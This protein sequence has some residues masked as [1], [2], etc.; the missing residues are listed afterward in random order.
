MNNGFPGILHRRNQPLMDDS[1]VSIGFSIT[2]YTSG[3]HGQSQ[4]TFG[5]DRLGSAMDNSHSHGERGLRRSNHAPAQDDGCRLVLGLGPTPDA[6][7]ADQL[8]AGAES[9]AQ[10]A[11]YAPAKNLDEL[12]LRY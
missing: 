8:P 4:V 5:L 2:S 9:R 1:A 6:N 7:S 11:C 10:R 12:C 3:S